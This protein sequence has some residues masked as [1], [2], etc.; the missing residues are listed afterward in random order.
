MLSE[1]ISALVVNN[2]NAFLEEHQADIEAQLKQ[3]V[4]QSID[5]T[6]GLEK[7]LYDEL[8]KQGIKHIRHQAADA[9]VKGCQAAFHSQL[10][11]TTAA[12][13]SHVVTTT[14]GTTVGASIAHA[15][16]VA[17]V[18]AVSTAV[19]HLAHSVA[20]KAVMH[21][22][23][24]HS[25]GLIVTAVLVHMI[26][27]HMTA[28]SAGAILGPLAWVAGGAFVFYKIVTIP[29]TL[30][31]ELG[32][33]LADD[34]RGKFRPWT[35]KAL[36]ACFAK[37][38]DPEELLKSVIKEEMDT[39]LPDIMTEVINKPNDPP[40]DEH[41]QKGVKKLVGYGGKLMKK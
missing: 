19:V 2:Y 10:G 26:A 24:G 7:I 31:E 16:S 41:V 38:T 23:I 39:F 6:S 21:T 12:T 40:A 17:V 5:I 3:Q 29:E 11:H 13:V 27:A 35:E 20:F 8:Q 25:V 9:F 1:P 32:E 14:V 22:I 18:H 36:E 37:M 34:M 28:A 30:G 33:A 15:L 4:A